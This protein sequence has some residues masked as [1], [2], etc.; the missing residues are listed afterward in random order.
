MT[1][2]GRSWWESSRQARRRHPVRIGRKPNR[3]HFSRVSWRMG[4]PRGE[5]PHPWRW[6]LPVG[7][8]GSR[9]P[10]WPWRTRARLSIG[11]GGLAG[12][13]C[14]RLSYPI[15]SGPWSGWFG[16]FLALERR[17]GPRGRRQIRRGTAVACPA[18]AVAAPVSWPGS[19]RGSRGTRVSVPVRAGSGRVS[20]FSVESHWRSWWFLLVT[21]VH[22]QIAIALLATVTLLFIITKNINQG[23][24]RSTT[25]GI[26]GQ[27]WEKILVYREY[28]LI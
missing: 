22:H 19:G 15:R 8:R 4:E 16:A 27:V 26:T 1:Y 5:R 2:Q 7:S 18:V 20:V 11:R 17:C 13:R 10:W 14:A 25:P 21:N 23:F 3:R 6:W 9:R 12:S 24:S 28:P